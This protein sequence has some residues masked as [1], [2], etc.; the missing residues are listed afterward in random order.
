MRSEVLL[1][2]PADPEN[3]KKKVILDQPSEDAYAAK[4]CGYLKVD[5]STLPLT[6]G[7]RTVELDEEGRILKGRKAGVGEFPWMVRQKAYSLE[8][9]N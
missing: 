7:S 9:R 4:S 1:C 6:N 3:S 5:K 8:S 2:C